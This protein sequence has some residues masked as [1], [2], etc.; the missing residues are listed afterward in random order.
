MIVFC[1]NSAQQ[2]YC[3]LLSVFC[4]ILSACFSSAAVQFTTFGFGLDLKSDDTMHDRKKKLS[5]SN[6]GP[7]PVLVNSLSQT[8]GDR[9]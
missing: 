1:Q 3:S 2:Q 6:P 9:H 8:P 5:V 7:R 4:V